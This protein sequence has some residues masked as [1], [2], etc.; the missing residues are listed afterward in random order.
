MADAYDPFDKKS[1]EALGRR[2]AYVDVGEGP[3]VVFLHGNPTS[4][5]LWRQV[6]PAVLPGYRA[7]APDLVG[8]GDSDKVQPIDEGTYRF[9]FHA[10][11]L[12]AFM[13][14][15][16]P[17]DAPALLVIHDWGSAL[18]F[19][20]AHR[21][22]GRVKGIVFMEAIVAPLTW[23]DWP[24]RA[25]PIFEAFRSSAGEDLILQNNAFVEQ[26]L[27]TSILRT[28]TDAEMEEYRRPFR[29]PGTDRLP[30]LRWPREI[31]IDG[32]PA[33]VH[34]IVAA[35]AEWLARSDV[36]KLFVNADP[37]AILRGRVREAVRA[38]PNLTEITVPGV[39]FVQ[40]DSG[41]AIGEAVRDFAD[42][43]W[44]R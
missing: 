6:I 25:R 28:L 18:G 5:Y 11:Y 21:N 26:V 7:L 34:R 44:A 31:P 27:P 8:M 19:H 39:H 1:L 43:L 10:E 30:T 38:W 17:A 36:P 13:D 42:R 33:D 37:G 9:R 15:V 24:A 20:W 22:P 40:E 14:A 32:E 35:Y 12:D 23:D 41:P 4:S 3:P 16:L 29:T 2:M